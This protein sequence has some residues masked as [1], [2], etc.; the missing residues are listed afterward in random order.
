MNPFYLSVISKYMNSS[1]DMLELKKISK[2]SFDY[3]DD[4]CLLY[5][6]GIFIYNLNSNSINFN[7]ISTIKHDKIY[8]FNQININNFYSLLL[9]VSMNTTIYIYHKITVTHNDIINDYLRK[10]I[11]IINNKKIRINYNSIFYKYDIIS[12]LYT[13]GNDEN[14]KLNTKDSFI[15]IMNT[16]KNCEYNDTDRF[17]DIL[18]RLQHYVIVAHTG[19]ESIRNDN[20]V[21]KYTECYNMLNY[22]KDKIY[23]YISLNN[24][25]EN[26][27]TKEFYKFVPEPLEPVDND[28][29]DDWSDWDSFA[30]EEYE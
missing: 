1:F 17:D 29:S 5:N 12:Y 10:C 26:D 27:D 4:T 22:I 21:N 28:N 23:N 2:H 16:I 18:N 13:I 14:Y 6:D 11:I 9:H 8:I 30:S 7:N 15:D 24:M 19:I 25:F 3:I 20:I